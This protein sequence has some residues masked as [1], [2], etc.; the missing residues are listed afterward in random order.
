MIKPK[1]GEIILT[2]FDPIIGHEQSGYRPALVV[3]NLD[4]NNAS[5]LILICPITNTNRKKP[6][7]VPL[8][9]TKTTGFILCEHVRAVDLSSRGYK[10]TGNVVAR[11]ILLRV[12]DIL[13]G[14]IDVL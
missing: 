12:A 7:D 14:A 13:Q 2:N 5:N 10:S 9:G 1:Q 6:M 3:S 4:F 8:D 11:E